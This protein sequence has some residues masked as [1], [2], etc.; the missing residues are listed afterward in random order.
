MRLEL[1]AQVRREIDA[2]NSRAARI[3][4]RAR[5]DRTTRPAPK[6]APKEVE[7]IREDMAAQFKRAEATLGD[8]NKHLAAIFA[9]VQDAGGDRVAEL[10]AE[11]GRLQGRIERLTALVESQRTTIKDLEERLVS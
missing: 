7:M 11:N 1:P 5:A 8:L 10:E 2:G 4:A 9:S 6:P 3:Y